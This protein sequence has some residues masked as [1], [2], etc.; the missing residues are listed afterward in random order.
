MRR[1][2][3]LLRRAD[4]LH[5]RVAKG[6][7]KY[8]R[9]WLKMLLKIRY[10]VDEVHRKFATFLCRVVRTIL[11]PKFD[12]S[13]MVKRARRCITSKTARSMVTWAHFRFRETLKSKTSLYIGCRVIICDEHFTS[14]TCGSCGSL[15]PT[16]GRSKEFV[17]PHCNY[18]ADRD[19]NAARNILLRYLT[20]E[21]IPCPGG[22]PF[23]GVFASTSLGGPPPP[24]MRWNV[25]I[26]SFCQ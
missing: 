7:D 26:G 4:Q 14:K 15:H 8:R 22:A 11:L 21:H 23:G 5:S 19:I 13:R 12:T 16:L 3:A 20:L 1:I 17:C 24:C 6:S 10:K 2:Y 18:S 25:P 9:P